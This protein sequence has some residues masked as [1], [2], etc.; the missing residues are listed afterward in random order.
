MWSSQN[1]RY[2]WL[3]LSNT[4]PAPVP[5]RKRFRP[6]LEGLENRTV[7]ST[8]TVMNNHDDGAGS[9]RRAIAHAQEGDTIVFDPS[10]NGQTITLT[11]G[12]L[13]DQE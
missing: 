12:Q 13:K 6:R 11:S 1:D 5:R 2:N 4:R 3:R 9:L 8:L 10:L 7:L